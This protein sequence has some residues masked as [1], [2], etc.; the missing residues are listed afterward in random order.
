MKIVGIIGG[1][2]CESSKHYYERINN[3]INSKLGDLSTAEI[4]MYSVN[5]QDIEPYMRRNDW[6]PIKEKLCDI[7]KKLELIGADIIVIATNTIHKLA[8]EIQS[9]INIPILHIADCVSTECLNQNVRKVGLLGTK[10]TMTEDFLKDRL[11]KNGLSAYVPQ[12]DEDIS[13]IDRIIFKELCIVNIENT[14]KEYYINVIN[15]MV[16]NFGIEGVI[17]G[18][19]EIEMLIQ[20]QDLEIPIFDT[21]Q[22]HINSIVNYILDN[23]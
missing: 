3:I 10:Y 7:A 5:F 12:S 17:L 22:A 23:I 1:M 2:S 4:I 20:P 15:N 16:K 6:K 11:A 9:S 18:C 13:K 14:S 21:T 19:T 8:D